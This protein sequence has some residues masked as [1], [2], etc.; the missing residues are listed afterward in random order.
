MTLGTLK[1]IGFY[2]CP[3]CDCVGNNDRNY[4][5]GIDYDK[6]RRKAI[7]WVKELEKN[8]KLVK[9]NKNYSTYYSD[10]IGIGKD[11]HTFSCIS[12]L[13]SFFNIKEEDLK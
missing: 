12:L 9:E 1:N 3:Y 7:K 8:K 10:L 5:K 13:K 2:H 6:L 11:F 4:D